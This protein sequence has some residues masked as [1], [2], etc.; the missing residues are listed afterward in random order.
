MD[1]R[2]RNSLLECDHNLYTPSVSSLQA[3][4]QS[5]LLECIR[6]LVEVD[7]DWVPDSDSASLYIRPTFISTEVRRISG[8][9]SC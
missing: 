6:R 3:F 8:C 7:Q 9:C 1:M 4:D 5:E 2:K